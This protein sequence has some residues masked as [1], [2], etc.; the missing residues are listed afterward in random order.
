MPD[1]SQ[2]SK[3]TYNPGSRRY[4]ERSSGRYVKA[5]TVR[6]AV[7][8]VIAAETLKIRS[9]SQSLVDG[10]INISEWQIQTQALLKNLHV[11]MGLAANGGLANTSDSDL[12]YIASQIKE[13]YKF[14]R[15]FAKQI[16]NGSQPLDGTLVSRAALYTESGRSIYE[17]V[18]QRAAKAG[19]ATQEK[20][21]LGAADHCDG[22]V[23]AASAG[24]SP[25]G[26]LVPIGQRQCLANCHCT[27]S[28]Q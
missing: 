5:E 23:E 9:V 21:I 19:G 26:S 18:V 16:K 4:A 14:L 27:M 25:I 2:V 7:D 12:G 24:W 20:S 22:C 10:S 17:A 3:F 13:Q 11:S 6:A 28:Y 15:S 8:T 1:T